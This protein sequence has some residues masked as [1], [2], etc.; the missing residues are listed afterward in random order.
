[1]ILSVLPLLLLLQQ[2]V[3]PAQKDSTPPA[4][5]DSTKKKSGFS[6]SVTVGG[7]EDS[8][9]FTASGDSTLHA[10]RRIPV[11]PAHIATAYANEATRQLVL[12]GR[13]ARL[14]VDSTLRSYEARTYQRISAGIALRAL[15]RSRL[16]AR[17]EQSAK[18]AWDRDRGAVVTITGARAVTPIDDDDDVDDDPSSPETLEL[19]YVPGED[20]LWPIGRMKINVNHEEIIHPLAAGAEAYYTYAIGDSLTIRIP[21]AG[22]YHLIELRV[23]PRAERWNAVVGSLWLD[24]QTA[25][26]VRAAYRL[27]A[28]LD[29]W[30]AVDED[31]KTDAADKRQ[32]D[33]DD[34][35]IPFWIRPALQ[36]MRLSLTSVTQE[37]S[38]Q[39]GRW[40]L[41]SFRTAE[42]LFEMGPIRSPI[43]WEEGFS[44]DAVRGDPLPDPSVDSLAAQFAGRLAIADSAAKVR[45][46]GGAGADSLARKVR[47]GLD[48]LEDR[49][50]TRCRKTMRGSRVETVRRD[51]VPTYIVIP[52]DTAVLAHSPDLPPS[53]YAPNEEL[54][55][56]SDREE[57]RKWAM[58]VEAMRPPGEE[59]GLP[60]PTFLFGLGGGLTRYNRV[61]GLSLGAR[62]EQ[63][64]RKGY[65]A[66]GLV[67]LGIADL[68]PGVELG[69]SRAN[70]MRAWDLTGYHRLAAAGDYGNPFTLGASLG[71]LLWGRD[72]GF[73][74]R[75][76][77]VELTRSALD[78]VGFQ[79]RLF[80]EH[81]G[82]AAV[83]SNVSLAHLGSGKFDP[84]IDAERGD[85]AGVGASVIGSAGEDPRGWRLI[86]D[87]RMEAAGGTFDYARALL[88]LTL[89]HPFALGT[90]AS[91]TGVAGAAAGQPPIQK[92][93]FVGGPQTVRGVD[94]GSEIG[95]A[96]WLTRA[97][98]GLKGKVVRP[99]FFGDVGWA[100]NRDDWQH[101]GTPLAGA[102]V[103]MSVLDGL[104][105]FDVAKAI[106]PSNGVRVY[107]YVDARF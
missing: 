51:G 75:A 3:A 65:V 43:T 81:H 68:N 2:P 45:A 58:S 20:R 27:S 39:G 92:M 33:K 100:G 42:G 107:L 74:Y 69:I 11:T 35:D 82:P 12:R 46:A 57:L 66:H 44:Y 26:L 15:A 14:A 50:G 88:D 4:K 103:G 77:G 59:G 28:P 22:E 73:Y 1:M 93:F 62:G 96:F 105:R 67:R 99:V 52:C 89:S 84:N 102:G 9:V 60:K 30:L 25:Q 19:P 101:P 64:L 37:F 31:N 24:R 40:W 18:V 29:V 86:S 94:A 97:E 13:E 16:A 61:E 90:T 76:T 38:L 10:V 54:F 32:H 91:V 98:L 71:A 5:S 106:N 79:W 63:K 41:P 49:E 104:V 85:I 56:S 23:N 87:A 47:Q 7:R 80:G 55:G 34:D 83:K 53:I 70:A 72:D 48:S 95:D 36:P 6:M 8:T 17:G 78:G 21:N